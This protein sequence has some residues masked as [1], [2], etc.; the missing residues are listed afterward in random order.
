MRILIIHQNFV[1]HQHPGGT[2]HLDVAARLVQKGHDV[3]IVASQVD[4]LTGRRIADRGVEVYSG[5]KVVR[6][7]ALPSV[8]RGLIWRTISYLSFLPCSF[9]TAMK[10]GPVDLVLGTTPPIFQLPSTWL[11]ARLRRAPFVL[12]VL[13]LWPEF[14]IGMGVL[15]NRLLIWLARRVEWFFYR[16]AQQLVVNSPAYRDYLIRGGIAAHRV[17]FIPNGVDPDLF[18]PDSQGQDVRGRLG[19]NQRFVV[20]YAGA[21]G[22]A[23]DLDTVIRAAEILGD[24][25]QICFLLAGDG[26]ERDRLEKEVR[27][28]GLHNVCF[29]GFFPKD[30]V[31]DVLA[32]SDVCLA[33][34]RDIPEFRTP[35][36]NKVFD[37]MAAGRAIILAIDGVIREVVEAAGSGIFV[38]PGDAQA[39]ARAVRRLKSDPDTRAAMARAGREYVIQHYH[40]QLQAD[41]FENVFG[42]ALAT[43]NR[44]QRLPT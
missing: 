29:A 13:D 33:T 2:R 4:Y 14:A 37:Y 30:R 18:M 38:P 15:K 28:R 7:Y 42:Q 27:R 31:R 17:T 22:M 1:D 5:V 35:F 39:L 40:I 41:R 20:T 32:A 24:D 3:T 10:A 44:P 16:V 19:L 34:L 9:W 21:L 6:A 23:N 11:V 26:K 12:E 25:R 36:P 43:T 8:Q